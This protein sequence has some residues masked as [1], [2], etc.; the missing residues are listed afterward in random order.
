MISAYCLAYQNWT[1]VPHQIEESF[2]D[3]ADTG[4]DAVCLSFSE[5]EMSYARYPTTSPSTITLTTTRTRR[6]SSPL[7]AG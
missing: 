7:C 6:R 2:A 5:S 1:V 4:F 3:M